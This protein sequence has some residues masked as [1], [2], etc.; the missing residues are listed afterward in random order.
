METLFEKAY[1][2]RQFI[3]IQEEGIYRQ[4]NRDRYLGL[5]DA[6]KYLGSYLQYI[7]YVEEQEKIRRKNRV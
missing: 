4:S 3:E 1:D 5:V 6:I 2:L 7:Q